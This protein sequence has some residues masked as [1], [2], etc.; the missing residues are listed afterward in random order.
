[1]RVEPFVLT[2]TELPAVAA[3]FPTKL[4]DIKEHHLVLAGEDPFAQLEIPREH[5]R[6][7]T[8]QELHN[9]TLR[10][11][12]R[13]LAI[14]NDR[15]GLAEAPASIARPLA[16]QLASLLRLSGREL[17]ADDRTANLMESAA[18]AF[19]FDREALAKVAALRRNLG[20]EADLPALYG[21]VLSVLTRA[22]EI[23]DQVKEKPQ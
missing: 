15:A 18:A 22:G 12:W 23:A 3:S 19:G 5:L 2:P 16:L 8:A 17:P 10:L 14:A 7:R 13:F 1:A 9:L 6:L 4:L 21:S 11:R 20:Q